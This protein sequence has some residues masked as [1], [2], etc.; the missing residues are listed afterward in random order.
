MKVKDLISA[1]E[2]MD[3]DAEIVVGVQQNYGSDFAYYIEDDIQEYKINS[4]WGAD[5]NA[6]VITIKDQCGTVDYDGDDED[7]DE[8]EED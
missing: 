7:C 4:Y 3:E 8:D 1:L 6:V 2:Y 5:Y